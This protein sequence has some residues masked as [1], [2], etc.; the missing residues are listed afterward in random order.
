MKLKV[1]FRWFSFSKIYSRCFLLVPAVHFRG[2]GV[3][4]PWPWSGCLQKRL[5]PVSN[6][7]WPLALWPTLEPD[8]LGVIFFRVLD[9]SKR[10]CGCKR[11]TS[12]L[13][14]IRTIWYKP[15]IFGMVFFFEWWL[16]GVCSFR[17][18]ISLQLSMRWPKESNFR[19]WE[20]F[21]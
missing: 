1:C 16:F 19:W 10:M 14:K 3:R 17:F 9:T 15:A 7:P 21:W 6:H 13:Y 2:S 12:F 18:L 8:F 5:G 4:W 20:T 11:G